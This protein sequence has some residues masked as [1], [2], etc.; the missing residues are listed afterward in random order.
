MQS[1][2]QIPKLTDSEVYK[3]V[4]NIQIIS[5]VLFTQVLLELSVNINLRHNRFVIEMWVPDGKLDSRHAC[6]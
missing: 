4:Y 2:C 5:A 3:T 6:F 1:F